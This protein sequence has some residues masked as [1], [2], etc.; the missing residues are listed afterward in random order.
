MKRG[1]GLAILIGA[2]I[3]SFFVLRGALPFIPIFGTSMEPGYHAG[4]LITIEPVSP[5]EVKVGDIIVFELPG[6]VREYY[7]YPEVVAH[8]VIKVS[9]EPSITYRTKGDNTGEDPF[10]VRAQDLKG[11]V[12]ERIPYLGLP[13]LFLQSRQGLIFVIVALSLLAIHLYGDELGQ[14]RKRVQRGI[15]S[16]V[17]DE[18]RHTSRVMEDGMKGTQRALEQFSSAMEEY[19]QHLKSHTSAIQGLSGASQELKAGAVEQNKVLARLTEIMEKQMGHRQQMET[20]YKSPSEGKP[21]PLVEDLIAPAEK[22][23]EKWTTYL[24]YGDWL[25]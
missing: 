14:S 22:P 9:A 23:K 3:A 24:E 12:G 5:R 4:D 21:A 10:T 13:L 17:I 25:E 2:V 16:P 6:A 20:G 19:A 7:N 15:F 11:R 18:T 8:R 1:M